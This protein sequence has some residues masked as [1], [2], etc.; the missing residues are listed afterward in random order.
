[1]NSIKGYYIAIRNI[2][3]T[4]LKLDSCHKSKSYLIYTTSDKRTERRW[5]LNFLYFVW[6]HLDHQKCNWIVWILC[7]SYY[8]N[9]ESSLN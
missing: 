2:L 8:N 7:N 5:T 9:D 3:F 6:A 4:N 1:M